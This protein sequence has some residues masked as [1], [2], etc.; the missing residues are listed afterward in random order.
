MSI[1]LF[2]PQ[3]S[4]IQSLDCES[5]LEISS[6]ET[7]QSFLFT[8]NELVLSQMKMSFFVFVT[9]NWSLLDV[10]IVQTNTNWVNPTLFALPTCFSLLPTHPMLDDLFRL[11]TGRLARM[12][13]EHLQNGRERRWG[14]RRALKNSVLLFDQSCRANWVRMHN[15]LPLMHKLKDAQIK[16]KVYIY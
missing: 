16:F 14:R 8:L 7:N 9:C 3:E 15:T 10:S 11:T 5:K 12:G 13:A 1:K 6:G 4:D 2:N